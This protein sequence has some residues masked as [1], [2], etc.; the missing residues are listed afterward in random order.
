MRIISSGATGFHDY[1]DGVQFLGQDRSIVY[2]RLREEILDPITRRTYPEPPD[3][4]LGQWWSDT[5]GPRIEEYRGTHC[6]IFAHPFWLAVAGRVYRGYRLIQRLTDLPYTDHVSFAY[7]ARSLTAAV[8]AMGAADPLRKLSRHQRQLRHEFSGHDWLDPARQGSEELRDALISHGIVALGA[9]LDH[10]G[11]T[12]H[13]R[14]PLIVNPRLA[15]F[16]FYRVLPAFT[17][18]QEIAMWI[19]GVLS[20]R[21]TPP[22]TVSDADRFIEHGFDART[23]FRGPS[24]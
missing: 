23:S 21:A 7:S 2:L 20:S 13:S 9:Y 14:Y 16:E 4:H 11:H 18:Y 6:K 17:V 10:E 19:G 22:A 3:A 8:V 12:N 15:D 5:P 24:R 1:Y